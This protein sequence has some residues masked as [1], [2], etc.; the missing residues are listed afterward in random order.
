MVY[1]VEQHVRKELA[2][3]AAH[4][5]GYKTCFLEVKGQQF[6]FERARLLQ[7]FREPLGM[8]EQPLE[9]VKGLHEQ[10]CFRGRHGF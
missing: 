1:R 4:G 6:Q 8:T 3:R 7:M 5:I 10:W 2:R 9:N